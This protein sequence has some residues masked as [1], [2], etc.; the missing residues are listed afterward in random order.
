MPPI[1]TALADYLDQH[2]PEQCAD[3][4]DSDREIWM[5]SGERRIVRHLRNLAERQEAHNGGLKI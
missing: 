4:K 3:P 1:S 2:Y 5:K